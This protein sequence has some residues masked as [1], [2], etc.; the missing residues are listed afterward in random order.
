MTSPFAPARTTAPQPRVPHD[1]EPSLLDERRIA[2][3]NATELLRTMAVLPARHPSREALRE[4]VIEVWLPLAYNLANRFA[5]RGEPLDDIIQTATIGLI[6]AI[7]KFDAGRGL[8]FTAYAVPTIIGE[9]KRHFRDRTWDLRVPRRIQELRMTIS[10]ARNALVQEL[11]REPTLSDIAERLDL[12][13]EEVLEGYEGTRAYNAVS[14]QAPAQA[15]D[16][17]GTVLGDLLGEEDH[18]YEIAE[19]RIALTPALSRL[20]ER[21]QRILML[22]FYGN[23]TQTQIAEQVGISQM[24]VSRLLAKALSTLHDELAD[25]SL[26]TP[27]PAAAAE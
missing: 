23:L 2:D 8:E 4:Q 3:D 7:D 12:T 6:K 21:T 17:Q 16:Q 19:L 1:D 25:T 5:N 15:E 24:H 13:E 14:L 9:I 10:N 27:D 20:D 18:G 26:T 11:G 22:R